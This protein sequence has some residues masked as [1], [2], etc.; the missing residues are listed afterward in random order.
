[1]LSLCTVIWDFDIM[2]YFVY[3]YFAKYDLVIYLL[4]VN[5]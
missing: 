3:L 4:I 5:Y 2:Y 1:M